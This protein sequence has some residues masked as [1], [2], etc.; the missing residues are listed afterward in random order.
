[1][2]VGETLGLRVRPWRECHVKVDQTERQVGKAANIPG[3]VVS[4]AA[5]NSE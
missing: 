2:I 3:P 5:A 4:K 1:M